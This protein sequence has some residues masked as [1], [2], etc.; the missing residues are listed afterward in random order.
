MMGNA[1]IRVSFDD[2][3]VPHS[4]A[5]LSSG[6]NNTS[7]DEDRC[8][9]AIQTN[10][11]STNIDTDY[12]DWSLGAIVLRNTY[13]VFDFVNEEIA[14]A[15]VPSNSVLVAA[16]SVRRMPADAGEALVSLRSLGAIASLAPPT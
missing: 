14:F 7:D 6:S 11:D 10:A 12:G 1:T 8:L 15:P 13:T 4:L 16:A 2:L 3:I 5:S 9:F